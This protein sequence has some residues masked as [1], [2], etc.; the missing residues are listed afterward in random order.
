M[1]DSRLKARDV[2]DKECQLSKPMSHSKTS[3]SIKDMPLRL[4]MYDEV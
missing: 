2:T 4:V 1:I 3:Q